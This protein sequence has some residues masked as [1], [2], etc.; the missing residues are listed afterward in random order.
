ML[1]WVNHA[2]FVLEHEDVKLICDPWLFG[3]AFADGW[4]LVA[5]TAFGLTDFASITHIWYSHEHPDHFVPRVLSSIEE[6]LRPQITVLYQATR[7]GKVLK[8][9]KSLGFKTL[10]LPLGQR[11]VLSPQVAITCGAVPFYDSWLLIEAGGKRVLNLN[12]CV[13]DTEAVARRIASEVGAVDVLLSQFNEAEWM[14]DP[15][16]RDIRDRCAAEKLRRLKLQTTALKPTYAIPFAS[17]FYFSHDE[18]FY[19][20]DGLNQVGDVARFLRDECGSEP[21][22]LYP[23]DTW[24][25]GSAH[26][27]AAA[28]ARYRDDISALA[29]IRHAGETVAVEDLVRM[30][31]RYS[32]RIRKKNN[33]YMMWIAS[34]P[35]V[36]VLPALRIYLD[37]L[38]LTVEFNWRTGLRTV[39]VDKADADLAMHSESLAY[40]FRFDWG[41]DTLTVNGRFRAK[42]EGYRRFIKTF[43]PGSLNNLGRRFG[44]ELIAD[45]EFLKR[46]IRMR[47]RHV[48]ASEMAR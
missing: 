20:N 14:G 2:S 1:R 11:T 4:D 43:A 40:V 7:D 34:S 32:N 10:E 24:V 3:P 27:N 37:D 44:L 38:Q 42:D 21:I 33:A 30:A 6:S 45:R 8:Y 5:K 19:L 13:V 18:N 15:D 16:R 22:V 9:C 41:M 36:G 12:D 31:D 23:G 28:I 35:W 46:I 39:A 47:K 29:P 26:D 25:P 17:F 48:D